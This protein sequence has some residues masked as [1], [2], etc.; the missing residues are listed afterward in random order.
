MSTTKHINNLDDSARRLADTGASGADVLAWLT[1]HGMTDA[2]ARALCAEIATDRRDAASTVADREVLAM[3]DAGKIF[4]ASPADG[5]GLTG[6]EFISAPTARRVYDLKER[7]LTGPAYQVRGETW[8]SWP[9]PYILT[10]AGRAEL[11]RA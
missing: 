3:I 9:Q 7:G 10:A 2:D 11:A 4:L 5:F 6:P 1:K 8:P